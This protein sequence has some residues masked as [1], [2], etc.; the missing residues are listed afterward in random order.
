MIVANR[1]VRS[2]TPALYPC[3]APRSRLRARG[4]FVSLRDVHVNR[5]QAWKITTRYNNPIIAN[6]TN[7]ANSAK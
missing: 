6:A 1:H 3:G 7:A 5:N 4:T 2:L